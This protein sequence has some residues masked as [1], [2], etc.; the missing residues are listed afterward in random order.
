MLAE[1]GKREV[2][3]HGETAYWVVCT[4]S[5]ARTINQSINPYQLR[6]TYTLVSDP[7]LGWVIEL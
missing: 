6:S 2:V 1:M 4:H 7:I 3:Y 5:L